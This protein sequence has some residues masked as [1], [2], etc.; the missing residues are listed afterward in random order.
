MRQAGHGHGSG[1]T[2]TEVVV[3][4]VD[5]LAQTTCHRV[6]VG[7]GAVGDVTDALVQLADVYRIGI[8]STGG[9][10]GDLPLGSCTTHRN[11]VVALGHRVGANGY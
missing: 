3:Q 11:A 6:G 1:D 2:R 9:D 10:V 7:I 8:G 4:L 5:V